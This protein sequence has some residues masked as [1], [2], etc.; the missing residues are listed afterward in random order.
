MAALEAGLDE[1]VDTVQQQRRSV[2]DSFVGQQRE[3]RCFFNSG[4]FELVMFTFILL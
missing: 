2:V 4:V 3:I 1:L